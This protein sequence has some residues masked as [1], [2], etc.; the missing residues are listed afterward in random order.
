MVGIHVERLQHD[1][2][3]LQRLEQLVAAEHRHVH[4][5]QQRGR[6]RPARAGQQDERAGLAEDEV[7]PGD[8]DLGARRLLAVAETGRLVLALAASAATTSRPSRVSAGAASK[9]SATGSQ[10]TRLFAP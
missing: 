7:G 9:P 2:H 10:V 4:V 6:A 8:A 3:L 5:G 1:A